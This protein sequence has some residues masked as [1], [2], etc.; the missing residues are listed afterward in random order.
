MKNIQAR[1]SE[2]NRGKE[3]AMFNTENNRFQDDLIIMKIFLFFFLIS[4]FEA[5]NLA[6]KMISLLESIKE[7][8]NESDYDFIFK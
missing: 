8:K 2:K 6:K 5:E 7:V 3:D 4:D 1:K